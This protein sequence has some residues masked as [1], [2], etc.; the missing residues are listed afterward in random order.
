ME[1]DIGNPLH[2]VESLRRAPIQEHSCARIHYMELKGLLLAGD[3]ELVRLANP[4]HGV[5][6][7]PPPRGSSS[8]I[9]S[10]E[11]ITWS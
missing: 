9:Y 10:C 5:E 2:G 4:L 11:S 8:S 7:N 6:R 3:G 1:M